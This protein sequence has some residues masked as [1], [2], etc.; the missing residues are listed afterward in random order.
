MRFGFL[1]PAVLFL[2]GVALVVLSVTTGT[3]AFGIALF[4]P[5]VVGRSPELAIGVLLIVGGLFTLPLAF[6]TGGTGDSLDPE[7]SSPDPVR[8]GGVVVIGPVPV[9]FGSWKDLPA[10]TRWIVAIGAAVVFALV[11]L[12]IV[13]SVA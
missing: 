1:V 8:G 2:A 4:V 13:W 6:A 10:R 7:R 11:V 5:F 9:F 12:V 3:A